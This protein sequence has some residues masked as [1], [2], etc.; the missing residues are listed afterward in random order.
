MIVFAYIA[1]ISLTF[2]YLAW[3]GLPRGEYKKDDIFL[4]LFSIPVIFLIFSR[5]THVFLYWNIWELRLLDVVGFWR[6]SGFELVAGYVAVLFYTIYYSHKKRWKIW[7]FLE[8]ICRPVMIFLF[9]WFV[10]QLL[11]IESVYWWNYAQLGSIIFA[12]ITD[13]FFRSRY[14]RL[15]WYP[16]GKKGF[17]FWSDHFFY[18]LAMAVSCVIFT[19]GKQYLFTYSAISV[20]CLLLLLILGNTLSFFRK[21]L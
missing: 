14:R 5:L 2:T 15:V 12:F 21:K 7:Y 13:L 17:L 4:F 16:N 18:F 3:R 6:K 1:F 9:I 8:D 19:P 10:Y 20:V 11:Y